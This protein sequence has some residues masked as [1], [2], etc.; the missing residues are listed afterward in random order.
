MVNDAVPF[1]ERAFCSP[2]QAADYGNF[3]KTHLF[4]NLLKT[5]AIES[6]KEGHRRKISVPSLIAYCEKR[7]AKADAA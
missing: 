3:G 4:M 1:K 5:G 2:R 6:I 7:A